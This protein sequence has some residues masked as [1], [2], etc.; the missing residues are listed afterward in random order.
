[1][2]ASATPTWA[3]DPEDTPV[4]LS[5][6][7]HN[8][9]AQQIA[10]YW[11]PLFQ[12]YGPDTMLGEGAWIPPTFRKLGVFGEGFHLTS[13]AAQAASGVRY[14]ICYTEEANRGAIVGV[15]HA[16]YEVHQLRTETW[17]LGRRSVTFEPA[18]DAQ[19]QLLADHLE[20]SQRTS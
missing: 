16:G 15:Y 9:Q 17:K 14:G 4:F 5:F 6:F 1:M 8:S 3:L 2:P 11:G 20:T 7:V 13:E 10:D 19:H 18:T 12:N